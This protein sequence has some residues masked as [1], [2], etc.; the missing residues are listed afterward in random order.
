MKSYSEKLKDPRWQKYRLAV[1]DRDN[2]TC[3]ECGSKKRTLHAHHLFYLKNKNPWEYPLNSIVTLCEVCHKLT[4]SDGA[5]EERK[6]KTDYLINILN[7]FCTNSEIESISDIVESIV[8]NELFIGSLMAINSF[9]YN[10][11][12]YDFLLDS[13]EAE[14]IPKRIDESNISM[15]IYTK[16]EA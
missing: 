11:S 14:K 13:F 8:N 16:N 15:L 2:F 10:K 4:H 5:K 12:I 6:E 1:F 7:S 9:I 3:R